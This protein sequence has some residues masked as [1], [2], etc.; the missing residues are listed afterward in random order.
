MKKNLGPDQYKLG[1]LPD[2]PDPR[3][4]LY[5]APIQTLQNLPAKVNLSKTCPPIYNQGHLGSCTANALSAA[6]HFCRIKE[7]RSEFEPSRLFLY[8]NER[9]M[10]NTVYSDSG[11]FIRDGI[12]SL[13]TEGIC[14]E[15]DWTYDDS[16]GLDAKFTKKP[17]RKCFNNAKK[18][19]VLSYQRI[20]LNLISIKGCLAEG[21][22]FTFGFTV[23]DS[24]Y[25][26]K[27]G[28]MPMPD[29]ATET[30]HGGHAVLAVGYDEKKQAVL[31]RN[32]WGASWGKKG[33]FWMPYAYITNR[34]FCNDFWTIRTVE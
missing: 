19:Q 11:A 5:A 13:N 10:I 17:P 6:F 24:F 21:Y 2:L 23:F 26:I 27:N 3:D 28:V 29:I 4:Y 32:S 9:V 16:T 7:K 18:N 14:P 8:Y 15:Q 22:P 1:W 25:N 31:I 12:K 33:Y 30:V 20:N 34:Q